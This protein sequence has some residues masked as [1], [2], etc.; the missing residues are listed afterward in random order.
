M[1]TNDPAYQKR[2]KDKHYADNKQ[3]YVDRATARKIALRDE[4][5]ELKRQPCS[6]CGHTFNPWQMQFDHRDGETKVAEIGYFIAR[7]SRTKLFEEIAKC[8]LVCANCHFERTY[9]RQQADIAQL[10]ER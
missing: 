7:N 6:D 8:D 5:W 10:A 9:Q 3:R 1:P 4:V 2:Y